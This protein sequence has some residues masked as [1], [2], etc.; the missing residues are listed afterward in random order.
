MRLSHHRPSRDEDSPQSTTGIDITRFRTLDGP[1]FKGPYHDVETFLTW[2]KTLKEFFRTKGVTLDF[3]R[4]TLVGNFITE[5]NTQAF[6]EAE[7]EDFIRR[8]WDEFFDRLF[9]EA[10]PA[11][12]E[13]K[14]YQKAQTLRMSPYED[15]KTYSTCARSIHNLV[16]FRTFK[17]S[18]HHMARFVELGRIPELQAAVDLW[19]LTTLSSDF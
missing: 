2:F 9:S 19:D 7:F 12:W 15:F 10:L 4:I 1:V 11:N 6:Y 18:D 8:S 5:P 14:L 16:N 3:E 13:D 17:V